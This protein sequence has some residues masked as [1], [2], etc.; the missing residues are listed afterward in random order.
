MI[1]T[2]QSFT[3]LKVRTHL[4]SA[5][6]GHPTKP[7][8]WKVRS[9]GSCPAGCPS[10]PQSGASSV[11]SVSLSPAPLRCCGAVPRLRC[12]PSYPLHPPLRFLLHFHVA[13]RRGAHSVS[14][15]QRWLKFTHFSFTVG[16]SWCPE[17]FSFPFIPAVICLFR[18]IFV[19]LL[20]ATYRYRRTQLANKLASAMLRIHTFVLC[21]CSA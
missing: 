19:R 12:V 14:A 16:V 11:S 21:V 3:S 6:Y 5:L 1:T 10:H 15:P 2:H 9:R 13:S 7:R 4:V 8:A 18:S 20:T 17:V